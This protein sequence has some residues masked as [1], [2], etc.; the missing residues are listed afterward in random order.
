M[1]ETQH[2]ADLALVNIRTC[3]RA[4]RDVK[5]LGSQ[6]LQSEMDA[7]RFVEFS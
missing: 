6:W 4:L 7:E 5:R 3:R 2:L 1:G